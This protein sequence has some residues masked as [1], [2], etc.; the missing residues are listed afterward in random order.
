M[1]DFHCCA[2]CIHF[3]AER[4]NKIMKYKCIRLSFNTLPSHKFDCWTPKENVKKLMIKEN[5]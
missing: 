5:R 3:S 2:T 1:K 4:D